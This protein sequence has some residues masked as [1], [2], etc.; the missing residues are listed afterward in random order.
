MGTRGGR[1][2]NSHSSIQKFRQIQPNA[3]HIMAFL[4]R[5]FK[6][7]TVIEV[8]TA[9]RTGL[10]SEEK[11]ERATET[12]ETTEN[13]QTCPGAPA[14]AIHARERRQ[15]RNCHG[16]PAQYLTALPP[17]PSVNGTTRSVGPRA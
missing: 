16:S 5:F 11:E 2:R 3:A 14:A 7:Y 10:Q 17:L 4:P 15:S 8:P 1:Q 12:M 9:V 6:L 13:S